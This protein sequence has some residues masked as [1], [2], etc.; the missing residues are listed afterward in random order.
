MLKTRFIYVDGTD[1]CGKDTQAKYIT[2]YFLKRGETVQ[3]R[4]HPAVD[5]IL[6]EK[7]KFYLENSSGTSGLVKAAFFYALD[8]IRS[9]ILY[10]RP[11]SYQ[12]IIFVRYLMGTAYLPSKF[13]LFGYRF[14][15]RL[16]PTSEFA[17]FVDVS[18]EEAFR[19]VK[20]RT[21]TEKIQ[22]EMFET[23]ET[24]AKMRKKIT[25]LAKLHNWHI[26]PGDDPP[27]VVWGT[28]KQILD[29]KT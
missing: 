17:F 16:L 26:I 23:K 2:R 5:N 27:E 25:F 14:F 24:L 7:A 19:R 12:N 18:P 28:I 22:E 13:S 29:Q 21:K 6:G 9:L 8:V 10:Y 4:S 1:G 15:A 11:D 3:L 20:F